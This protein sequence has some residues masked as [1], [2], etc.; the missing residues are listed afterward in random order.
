MT[1]G[2]GSGACGAVWGCPMLHPAAFTVPPAPYAVAP[3][4]HSA[5]APAPAS[6][7]SVHTVAETKRV[8]AALRST[9]ADFWR[10]WSDT[11]FQRGFQ[12]FNDVC[13]AAESGPSGGGDH[14]ITQTLFFVVW[15]I[16]SADSSGIPPH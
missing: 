11:H 6:G 3:Y 10:F 5:Y 1:G 13:R 7:T 9:A 4:I 16:N 15:T 12:I 14:R 8:H 2:G